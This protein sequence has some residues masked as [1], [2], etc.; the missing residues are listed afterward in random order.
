MTVRGHHVDSADDLGE[1]SWRKS[2]RSGSG[3]GQCV[4]AAHLHDG[5]VAVRDSK[6][7]HGPA[8]LLSAAGW[9]TLRSL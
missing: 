1:L 6:N 8:L 3:G 7:P 4:E 2:S 9:D 5:R